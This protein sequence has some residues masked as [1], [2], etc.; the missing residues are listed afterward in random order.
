LLLPIF[1]AIGALLLSTNLAA[2]HRARDIGRRTLGIVETTLRGVELVSQMGSD[3]DR[4]RLLIDA[5]IMEKDARPMA[6]FEEKVAELDADFAA[7]GASYEQLPLTAE[8]RAAFQELEKDVAATRKPLAETI[9]LSRR[10][11]DEA[12][13]QKFAEVERL[14]DEAAEDDVGALIRLSRSSAVKRVA[15]VAALQRSWM[16]VHLALSAVGLL[17]LLV[18]FWAIRLLQGQ[19]A[20]LNRHAEALE[21]QNRELDAFAARVAHDLRGPLGTV[22]LAAQRLGERAPGERSTTALL[23][24]AVVRMET[25]IRDLLT[26]S[27]VGARGVGACDPAR[28]IAPVEEELA[29]R[30]QAES[31]RLHID[32]ESASVHTSEGL[33]RQAIWNLADNAVKYRRPDT[34]VEIEI[35]G[36]RQGNFYELRVA[37]NG[38]GMSPDESQS[39]FAPFYRALRISEVPGTGLGL[40]IVK[41]VVE[42]S[43]GSISV[44]SQVGLGTTFVIHLPILESGRD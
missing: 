24:R 12:A 15:S 41:R 28:A 20:E 33:L 2:I 13:R 37:D 23:S 36:S 17:S 43:G 44:E 26:L 30:V 25:L 18:A 6:R 39:A 10:N 4:E 19:E 21:E 29:P 22:S 31:G 5:H 7:A 35:T 14:F 38:T 34:P 42:A 11:E 27:Q 32:V 3:V 8:E 1:V 9:A 40:S 16:A